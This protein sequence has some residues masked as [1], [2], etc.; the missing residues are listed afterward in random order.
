MSLSEALGIYAELSVGLAGFGGVAAAFSGREREFRPAE[1]LRLDALL[2][3][4]GSVFVG[5]LCFFVAL[6]FD[7]PEIQ[8]TIYAAV[9]SL[10]ITAICFATVVP[11]A[12]KA[13]FDPDATSRPGI[14]SLFTFLLAVTLISYV[15][16]IV[17]EGSARYLIVGFSVQLAF[18]LWMFSRLLTRA[19]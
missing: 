3:C 13:V 16:V 17:T 18:G 9:G 7:H 14:T 11:R 5:C 2:L 15:G 10:P 8:A 12:W 4:A 6:V 19:N 1:K